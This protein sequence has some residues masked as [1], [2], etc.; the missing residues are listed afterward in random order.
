MLILLCQVQPIFY[1]PSSLLVI[2]LHIQTSQQDESFYSVSYNNQNVTFRSFQQAQQHISDNFPEQFCWKDCQ[3][4][5][6]IINAPIHDMQ[7]FVKSIYTI[8]DLNLNYDIIYQE[9]E[10]RSIQVKSMQKQYCDNFNQCKQKLSY[11]IEVL[12]KEKTIMQVNDSERLWIIQLTGQ[13][14]MVFERLI[15]NYDYFYFCKDQQG[16]C[17]IQNNGI[18]LQNS[19]NTTY[20]LNQKNISDLKNSIQSPLQ[21]ERSMSQFVQKFIDRMQEQYAIEKK[22]NYAQINGWFFF[23]WILIMIGFSLA[24][25]VT[26]KNQLK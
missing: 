5:Q 21:V 13:N 14:N 12:K 19:N 10:Q 16:L 8:W 26:L 15:Q 18:I 25:I 20:K 23:Y 9:N 22:K 11:L 1:I 7:L 24:I 6:I 3:Q 2:N 4:S 17:S